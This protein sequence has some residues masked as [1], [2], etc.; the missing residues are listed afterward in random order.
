[1][2]KVLR[3]LR[4]SRARKEAVVSTFERSANIHAREVDR[5]SLCPGRG[6]GL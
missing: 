2:F 1:M 4:P 3:G 5:S 6:N